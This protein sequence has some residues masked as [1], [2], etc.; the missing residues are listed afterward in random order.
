M[1][2]VKCR[3][4]PSR[5]QRATEMKHSDSETLK[6]LEKQAETEPSLSTI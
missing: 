6:E 5:E 3:Q 4:I 1:D 2:E